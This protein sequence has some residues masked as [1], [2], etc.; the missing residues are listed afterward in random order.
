M[1]VISVNL[2]AVLIA[3]VINMVIGAFWYS[4]MMFAK[5]WMAALGKTE[6]EIKSSSSPGPIYAINTIGNLVLAYVLAHIV[7]YVQ[8]S[9][10]MQGA[11]VG[12]WIWLGFLVP[13]LLTVYMFEGRKIKL[14]FIYISY[15]L[16]ALVLEGIILTILV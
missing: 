8:A 6:E 11:Q 2:L 3:A 1:P 5:S 12:F 7:R 15:Q 4:P 16:I 10:A 14:Y 9:N 13:V